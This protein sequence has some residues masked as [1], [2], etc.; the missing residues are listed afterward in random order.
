M[1]IKVD[2]KAVEEVVRRAG[3]KMGS[4][5]SD[6]RDTIILIQVFYSVW[7]RKCLTGALQ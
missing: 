4:P 5:L 2:Y 7:C 1:D 6:V 3:L